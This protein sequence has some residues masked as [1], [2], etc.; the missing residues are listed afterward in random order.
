MLIVVAFVDV[1]FASWLRRNI[2]WQPPGPSKPWRTLENLR[3]NSK[4][5]KKNSKNLKKTSKNLKKNSKNLKKIV[6]TLRKAVFQ[7]KKVPF[8]NL[9]KCRFPT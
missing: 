6:K 2:G 4:N 1:I 7:P 8:S 3:K 9:R 5:L